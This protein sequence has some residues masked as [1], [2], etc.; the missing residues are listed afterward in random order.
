MA[1]ILA[2]MQPMFIPWAGYFNLM[3]N[4]DVFV[5]LDDV[6]LEKQSWQTRN[7]LLLDGQIKWVSL[8]IEHRGLKQ[9]ISETRIIENKKWFNS[10]SDSFKRNY[11]KH[12]YFNSAIEIIDF[13][14]NNTNELLSVRNEETII[15]IAKKLNIKTKIYRSSSLDIKGIRSDRLIN[16]CSYFNAKIYLSAIGSSNYLRD[17]NF[18][19][20]SPSS[21]L[22]Q[23]YTPQYYYQKNSENFVSHLSIVDVVANMGWEETREYIRG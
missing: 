14:L 23:E 19:E 10:L 7:R 5:F 9:K 2:V 8:P 20:R 6:Q 1:N 17:D 15:F 13:F 21:L 12:A 11:A 18:N 16:F 4:S 3:S 22:F